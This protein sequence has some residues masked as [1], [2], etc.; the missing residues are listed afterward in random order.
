M[1]IG[2]GY[3]DT[4]EFG[5]ESHWQVGCIL[6]GYGIV[7]SIVEDTAMKLKCYILSV[8]HTKMRVAFH[9]DS[10]DRIEYWSAQIALHLH[11]MEADHS[12]L[13]AV[14]SLMCHNVFTHWSVLGKEWDALGV[15]FVSGPQQQNSNL[16][17]LAISLKFSMSIALSRY[18]AVCLAMV[19]W[20][21]LLDYGCLENRHRLIDLSRF[22]CLQV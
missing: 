21:W 16:A 10:G 22:Q 1:F 12:S 18:W 13:V 4:M 20:V 17:C 7:T 14:D 9:V 2:L 11:G 8:L 5:K 15:A 19:A 6:A 3:G